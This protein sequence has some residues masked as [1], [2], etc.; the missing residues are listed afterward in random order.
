MSVLGKK[1]SQNKGK[2]SDLLTQD[3]DNESV[4][5]HDPFLMPNMHRAI[6]RIK[7]A[8]NNKERIVVFGDYDVDGVSATAILINVLRELGGEVSYRLPDRQDGYGLNVAWISELKEKK[9]DLLITV[10]CGISNRAEIEE[11]NNH[12]I[13]V[14]IT[15]HHA[16]PE[17]MPNAYAIL[18]PALKKSDYPFPHL[19]GAGIAFKLGVALMSD[20][21]SNKE[22]QIWREKL[23]DLASLGTIADCVPLVGENRW[24]AKKGI[25]QMKQT[26]WP[27]L[28]ILLNKAGVDMINGY[29]SDLVGFRIAPRL[30]AAG[31]L[32]T[33]YFALQLLLDENGS[34]HSLAEKLEQLNSQRQH[35]LEEALQKAEERIEEQ[36]LLNKKVL[37]LWDS[38]WLSGIVGLVAARLSEKH[39]RPTI[40]MEEREGEFVAS[41]RSP[42]TFNIVKALQAMPEIFEAF[43]GHAAAAGF[44]LKSNQLTN[45]VETMEKYAEKHINEEDL[46]PIIT[47]DYEVDLDE[48]NQSLLEKVTGLEPYGEGNPK[49]RFVVRAVHPTALQTVGREHSHLRFALKTKEQSVAAIAFRFGPHYAILQKALFD[50]KPVDI[51]FELNKNFWRGREQM[52]LRVIDLGIA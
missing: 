40:V 6:D 26:A 5:F 33:P 9:V 23:V 21:R 3:L 2:L 47:I 38:D 44:T 16:V 48:I 45:F 7:A 50:Q 13:D 11:A 30:N 17:N 29:D 8:L 25:D 1:W 19:S 12:G 52:Q 39:H 42:E 4:M 35:F 41:C 31:R 34:A 14:I 46:E 36:N 49:P 51:V 43:G 37:I 15:D 24:I 10:D 27:G 32:E 22:A 18:H 20:I 28:K